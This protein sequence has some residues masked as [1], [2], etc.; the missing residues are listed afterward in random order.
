MIYFEF[1]KFFVDLEGKVEELCVLVCKGEGVDFE[2]EVV[3]FDCKV[4]EMLCD[5]Y[6][7]FDFW[8]KMQVVCYFECLYCCDYIVGFFS[9]YI[10]LV[11]DRVFGED[12]VVMGGFVWFCDVFCVII[13]YEKGNDIKFCIMYNFGMVWF[14]GYCKVIWLMDIVDCFCLLVIM[15]VDIFGVYFGKGVEECGQF[16]VIVC[17]IEKCLQIGVLLILV[18]IG[19]GG[20]GGVVV[21]VIVN[22]IVMLE[23]LIYLVILFEGCVLILW[24][25]VEKMCEVVNVLCLIV[26]DL[27]KLDVIDCIIFELMGG[28]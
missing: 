27:K 17:L 23:Y 1:E 14:E 3:G 11:G 7:Q 21:F 10:F 18:V 15:L 25:D 6:K 24:K 16:E 2:K 26:Q 12:Y 20:L 8:C 28:V 5:L 19:E 4:E 13:G 22:C 9:E